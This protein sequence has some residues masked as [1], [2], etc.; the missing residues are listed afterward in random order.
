MVFS[1]QLRPVIF[2]RLAMTTAFA[3]VDGK[4][5]DP[6][7]MPLWRDADA[8]LDEVSSKLLIATTTLHILQMQFKPA[9]DGRA[10]RKQEVCRLLDI[11]FEL[12]RS[13]A[14]TTDHMIVLGVPL[15][16]EDKV[17]EKLSL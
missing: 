7:D 1:R 13:A 4:E 8:P 12:V 10:L 3:E 9:L 17:R 5:F 16:E 15:S 14:R 11:A 2:G 6:S